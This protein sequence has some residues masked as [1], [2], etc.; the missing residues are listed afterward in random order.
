MAAPQL[1]VRVAANLA[2]LK[3][4]L[5]EGINQIE[6]TSQSLVRMAA[7][8]DGSKIIQQAGATAAAI[9]QIGGVT[10]LT[11]AE[12]A[13]ANSILEAALAKYA[14][15][16]KEA[17][18]GMRALA[19]A[20]KQADDSTGGFLSKLADMGHSFVARVAEGILLRDAIREV[21][22]TVKEV[23]LGAI[24]SAVTFDNLA[25]ATGLST[26][27]IQQFAYVGKDFGLDVNE[28]ARGVEQL[29]A[30]L[31]NG[32][33]NAVKAVGMLGLKV[34]E[35]LAAGPREAFL[36][37]VDAASQIADPMEKSAVLTEVF[38]GKLGK[39]I[40]QLPDLR[41]K[42]NDVPKGAII[43][44][45]A[46]DSLHEGKDA[47]DHFWT[48]VE[49]GIGNYIAYV[50]KLNSAKNREGVIGDVFVSPEAR[51]KVP[52]DINLPA[53]P[54]QRE[55]I[56]NATL[57][58]NRLKQLHD[59]AMVP[60]NDETQKNILLLK[61]W[62]IGEQ[63][64]AQLTDTN[65]TAVH[66]WIKATEDL[67]KTQAAA[68][69]RAMAGYENQLKS[70]REI[71]AA[72]LKNYSFEGQIANLT[73]L[74][75][76]ERALS[77]AVYENLT[78]ETARARVVEE[79]TK[80]HLELMNQKMEAQRTHT[81]I[82]NAAVIAEFEAQTKLNAVYGRDA[83]G[84]IEVQRSA[85]DRLR[86]ALDQLHLSAVDGISQKAQERVLE[87]AYTKSLLDEAVAQDRARDALARANG[88]TQKAIDLKNQMFSFAPNNVPT[89]DS[90]DQAARRPGSFLGLSPGQMIGSMPTSVSNLPWLPPARAS[91]GPVEGGRPYMVGERGPELYVPERSGSIVPNGA[92]TV[93]HNHYHITQ[94]L[95]TP[96][97]IATAVGNAQMANLRSA[98]VRLPTGA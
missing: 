67:A 81:S 86:L 54:E 80:R 13:K 73:Q 50:A 30:K 60:L 65:V 90:L 44:K 28:M 69:T 94:P 17:P 34:R 56:S 63:E 76:A 72:S 75:A 96:R 77:R 71:T 35:L 82:V 47:W 6:I 87:D 2:D 27:A 88:E 18:P 95:G 31:A 33:Q 70:I 42:L 16:G 91:G 48:S 84:A 74:D 25:R 15:L 3:K 58:A 79:T 29:S 55:A 97:Q 51:P 57:L 23:A 85:L 66:Q 62:G 5:A 92:G 98:G 9:Q 1:V 12:Q 37:V 21:I 20:T 14:A 83:A 7:S 40:S 78:S 39:I 64:I 24:Q 46:I 41:D 45:E 26:D 43:S 36:Q 89:G 19:D 22:A 59:D 93:V 10:N 53:A 8:Y 38:G 68:D 11:A 49:A 52:T 61:Q 4:N 32:D